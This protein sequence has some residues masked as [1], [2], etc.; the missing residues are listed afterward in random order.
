M[1]DKKLISLYR[2]FDAIRDRSKKLLSFVE[3]FSAD[4]GDLDELEEKLSV[5]DDLRNQFFDTRSKLYG[6]VKDDDLAEIGEREE[7]IEDILDKSRF[8]IR[9]H[10]KQVKPPIADGSQTVKQELDSTN[11]KTKLPDIPLPKFDGHYENWIFFR[12]QFKSIICRRD[13]LDDFERL[14]Y[15]RMCLCGEAKNLQCNEESFHLF[16]MH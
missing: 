12:D 10:L 5:L 6:L 9:R 4:T 8:K 7:E 11:S 16:G 14:H 13:N 15:L 1:T 2:I 3:A